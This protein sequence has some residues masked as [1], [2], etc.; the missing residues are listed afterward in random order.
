MALYIDGI[1]QPAWM[2]EQDVKAIWFE[3]IGSGTTTGTVSKPAGAGTDVSFVMDEWGTATDAL[4]S[5]I[6]EGKPTYQSPV[7]ASGD[8]ITT[9]FNTSGEYT[10]SGTPVP[11]AAHAL[12]YV[13]ICDFQNYVT[14]EALTGMELVG[15]AVVGSDFDA[16]SFLYATTKNNPESKTP[17]EVMAI[18]SGESGAA[19]DFGSTGLTTDVVDESTGA[20]GVTIESLLLKD[21]NITIGD[22]NT[23][24][25]SAGPLLTFD[26]TNDLLTA[27][28][29]DVA[30][31]GD[32]QTQDFTTYTEVDPSTYF[33]VTGDTITVTLLPRN[34]DAYIYKDFG[35]DNF[36]GNFTH[37]I[38]IST[39]TSGVEIAYVWMLANLV[40]DSKGIDDASGDFLGLYFYEND[41]I[42]VEC[43][44]GTTYTASDY[45]ISTDGTVYYITIVRDEDVGT[46]GT[47]YAYIYSD[48]A[49]TTLLATRSIA[50]HSSKKDFRYLYG[51]NSYNSGAVQARSCVISNLS[52]GATGSLSVSGIIN[53]GAD[54]N[55]AGNIIVHDGGLIETD[56]I[57][58]ATTDAGVTIDSVIAKDGGITL[59]ASINLALGAGKGIIFG[60]GN[61]EIYEKTDNNLYVKIAGTDRWEIDANQ[62]RALTNY[63][64]QVKRAA[65][66][67]GSPAFTFV[68]DTDTGIYR[69]TTDAL[70]LVAGGVEGIRVTE[71]A[72][73]I[74]VNLYGGLII[75]D[76]GNIGSE[77]DTDAIAISSAGIVSITEK[78]GV[79]TTAVPHGGVGYAKLAI[80]GTNANAAGPHIQLTT[81]ADDY[82]LIQILPYTHDD[83]HIIF[84]GY[85]DGGFKSSDAGSNFRIYKAT[86]RIAIGYD[87]GNAQGGAVVWNNGFSLDTAGNVRIE[88]GAILVGDGNAIGV[89]GGIGLTF[90]DTNSKLILSGGNLI[91]PDAGT[92][93]SA[94]DTDAIAIAADGKV[95]LSQDLIVT[96][97]ISVGTDSP[98]ASFS[99]T[100]DI[101]ATSGIKAMEGLYSEAVAY[102]AGLEV[103][104]N[105]LAVTYTNVIYGD[106]TLTAATQIIADSHGSFDS[107]YVGQFFKVISSTPSFTGAT[108]EIV[109][110]PTSTTLVVSFG[111]AG[112]DTIVDATAMSFV[113]YPEPRCFIGDNGDVHYCIGEHEDASF[114]IC[115][116]ISNNEHAVHFVSK[117]GVTGNRALDIEFD[118]DTYGGTS[119]IRTKIDATAFASAETVG[120][121][122][123]VIVDN[124]GATAGDVHG[125][126]V[127]L[128][129]PS[130]ASLEVEAVATH[131]GVDVIGQ[132]LGEPAALTA[133][134]EYDASGTSY[135]DR[136]TAFNS[137]GTDVQIFDADN[138]AILLAS[139]AKFDEIN[140]VLAVT[141][142]HTILPTFHFIK[143]D[144]SWVEFTP[145]DDTSGFTGNGT[146]RFDSDTL[147]DWGVRT[148]NEVTGSGAADDYY[149]IK[150]TRT[151]NNLVRQPTEDTIQVTALGTKMGW[152]KDGDVNINT[153]AV[154]DGITAPTA[155][156][157][158]AIIYVDTAD[159]DLK[160]KFGNGFVATIAADS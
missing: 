6:N 36:S 83:I 51:V 137:A 40:D 158:Q 134:F 15:D 24:G 79:G 132:Y 34:V 94:S 148:I 2:G 151:R 67:V 90:D 150:I 7:D 74:S 140:V 10:F 130:N 103:S 37:E 145:S 87:S 85:Y 19:F 155:I 30:I 48:A 5:T 52:I 159:G 69:A 157:G 60:D 95:T 129:D 117:A 136:T 72:A 49:K 31:T 135:T 22:G 58:E 88:N 141:A 99:G 113:V 59:T 61:T 25:Q 86:D 101:Y 16:T 76:A 143:D 138:D 146:V 123:D 115:A 18:L 26:D 23:I 127:A 4:V 27:S 12:I 114:K 50:L 9:T 147:T 82:P 110:A 102:G 92:I 105:S 39:T 160:V 29:C 62:F 43:D 100:G 17:T 78:L 14:T 41:I 107:T 104:D 97:N 32:T 109:A 64:G 98:S 80:E 13:Y 106:A 44:G 120:T 20:A 91:I 149:W 8:P 133:G 55:V 1:K 84:D 21:G 38:E 89:S 71:S 121:V 153:M 108:G 124:T 65:G 42:L 77:S 46:Y 122:L 96:E 93:G 28:G 3:T 142:S 139:A 112:G 144:G 33:A 66:T 119:V 128:G 154:V 73:A 63:G 131:E 35:V 68:G 125:I 53:A 116:D 70:S 156:S 47:I 111:T 75:P 45:N 56:I 11:A 118:P 57:N 81:D 54:I 152:N 126:D